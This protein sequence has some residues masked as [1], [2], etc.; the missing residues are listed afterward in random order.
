MNALN[1]DGSLDLAITTSGF[2]DSCG[3]LKLESYSSH[4]QEISQPY[5]GDLKQEGLLTLLK[6][7]KFNS[8]SPERSKFE[9]S[10]F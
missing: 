6:I 3:E 9:Q 7:V 10:S 5:A 2:R 1:S 8:D 4:A